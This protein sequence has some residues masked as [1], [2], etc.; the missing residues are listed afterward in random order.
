MLVATAAGAPRTLLR[1]AFGPDKVGAAPAF[2]TLALAMAGLAV[3]VLCTHYLLGIGRR[4]VV[5]VLAV[6]AVMLGVGLA[7]AHGRP[8]ATARA[9]LA[10][11]AGLAIA[12]AGMV[13]SARPVH[14]AAGAD[15]VA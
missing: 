2:A 15:P 1:V 6:A 4:R 8:V 14:R 5:G 11:Q 9:E 3:S 13:V 7:A 10:L 12:L